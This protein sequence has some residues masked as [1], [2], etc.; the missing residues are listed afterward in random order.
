[1]IKGVD[2][3]IMTQRA[4]EYSKDVSAMLRR[5]ELANEFADRMNK[6]NAQQEAKTVSHLEKAEHARVRGDQEREAKQQEQRHKQAKGGSP[7]DDEPAAE[8]LAELPSVGEEPRDRLLD[9][10]V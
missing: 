5:D 2:A 9:I 10:E 1:M 7:G 8:G 4:A 6:L 3:Q